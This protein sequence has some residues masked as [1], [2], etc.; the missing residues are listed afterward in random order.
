MLDM[1][2]EDGARQGGGWAILCH[3]GRFLASSVQAEARRGSAKT[4]LP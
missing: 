3:A 1:Q 4:E 2:Y